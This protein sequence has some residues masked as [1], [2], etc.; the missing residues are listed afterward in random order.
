MIINGE[1]QD[2]EIGITIEDLLKKLNIDAERIVIE[3]DLEIIPKDEFKTKKLGSESKV[4]LI[5]FVG[6]G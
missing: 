4:E 1:E 2:F 6:G 3:V 5:R